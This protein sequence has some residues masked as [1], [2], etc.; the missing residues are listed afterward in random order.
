MAYLF[1]VLCIG[2]ESEQGLPFFFWQFSEAFEKAAFVLRDDFRC[3]VLL[4]KLR[5]GDAERVAKAIQDI[6]F[7]RCIAFVNGSERRLRDHGLHGKPII[8]PSAIIF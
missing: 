8:R 1:C 5:K 3:F 2:E 6:Q 4:E 7:W